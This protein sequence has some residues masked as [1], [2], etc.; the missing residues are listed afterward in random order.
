[1]GAVWLLTRADVGRHRNKLLWLGVLIGLVGAAVLAPVVGAR[2]T[3]T[4]YD[5]L[6]D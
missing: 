3:A 1:M 6:A 4:A 2:R 5:R